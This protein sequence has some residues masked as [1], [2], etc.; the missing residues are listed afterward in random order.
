MQ[1]LVRQAAQT[2]KY[3][4]SARIEVTGHADTSLS[5]NESTSIS[6]HMAKAVANELTQ[7]G[8]PAETIVIRGMGEGIPAKATAD[9]VIESRNRRVEIAIK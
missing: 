2:A 1:K 3:Y 6:I 8:V 5:D 7:H 4:K 9:G